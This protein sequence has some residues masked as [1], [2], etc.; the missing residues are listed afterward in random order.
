MIRI[1][2]LSIYDAK[3]QGIKFF[4]QGYQRKI[5]IH[6]R[7][8]MIN[9]TF[10]DILKR[11]S[12][13]AYKSKQIKEEELEILIK[14]ALYAPSAMNRQPWYFTIIQKKEYLEQINEGIKDIFKNSNDQRMIQRAND[15][16]FSIFYN[17]PTLIIVSGEKNSR[18]SVMDCSFATQNILI[19]AESL[20][21]GT[22]I[23]GSIEM[24]FNT[25]KGKEFIKKIGIPDEY[26]PLY[27]IVVGYKAIEPTPPS[28][29][30]N[31]INIIK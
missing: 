26:A 5:K 20:N 2:D 13:R 29:N 10:N 25:E 24:F 11:R 28:R 31:V 8:N 17:A 23:I 16:Q 21:I 19:A 30:M 6:R 18:F 3:A 27:A 12:I 7:D 14:A 22:C 1:A 4:I 15:P 9:Q